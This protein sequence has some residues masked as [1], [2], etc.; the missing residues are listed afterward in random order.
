[1]R[2]GEGKEGIATE[3]A[4]VGK[5]ASS[6]PR[7]P[8]VILQR[9]NLALCPPVWLFQSTRISAPAAEPSG[10]FSCTRVGFRL[11]VRTSGFSNLSPSSG[12]TEK[13]PGLAP[14]CSVISA[15]R[16]SF[17]TSFKSTSA[18]R[19]PSKTSRRVSSS[20]EPS[21]WVIGVL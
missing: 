2:H 5:F 13:P 7:P 19:S 12:K 9:H 14:R 10:L 16:T 6:P 15:Y 3:I 17:M 4:H 11:H 21:I 1:M 8:S 20:K 18:P